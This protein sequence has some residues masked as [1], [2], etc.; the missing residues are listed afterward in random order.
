MLNKHLIDNKAKAVSIIVMNPKNG[1][2]L[3]MVNKPDYNSNES[4][5]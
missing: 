3:A 4:L 2:I 5:G 1:E